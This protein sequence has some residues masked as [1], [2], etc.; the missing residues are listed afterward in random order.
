MSY[1]HCCVRPGAN[2]TPLDYLRRAD[3]VPPSEPGPA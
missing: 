3:P 1:R 2:E